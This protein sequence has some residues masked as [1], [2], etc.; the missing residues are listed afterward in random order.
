MGTAFATDLRTAFDGPAI[1]AALQPAAGPWQY[2]VRCKTD[3]TSCF[4][5]TLEEHNANVDEAVRWQAVQSC[6]QL[7]GEQLDS[8]ATRRTRHR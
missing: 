1:A 3:G 7:L 6:R 8:P 5:V 4:A 2:F